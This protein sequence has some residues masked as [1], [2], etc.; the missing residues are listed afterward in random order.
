LAAAAALTLALFFAGIGAALAQTLL[1]YQANPAPGTN[2]PSL[3]ALPYDAVQDL[4]QSVAGQGTQIAR[5]VG[6][7]GETGIEVVPGGYRLR[8]DP[9]IVMRVKAEPRQATLLAA[10]L[11]Y[12]YRQDS[13]L[14]LDLAALDADQFYV[15]IGFADAN[16]NGALA[17]AFFRHAAQVDPALGA[18]YTA[19]DNELVFINLRDDAGRP[20]G[21][22][23]DEAFKAALAK[24]AANFSGARASIVKTGLVEARLVGNDWQALPDGGTYRTLLPLDA[25]PALDAIEAR[26]GGAVRQAAGKQK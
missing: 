1:I 12:V 3:D 24:A 26:I 14:V 2:L 11:G 7:S 18:G 5:A 9:S 8:S 20:Y 16:L 6:F 13:V 19:F 17:D 25:L 10:A 4:T 22:L 23:D 15:R 21:G